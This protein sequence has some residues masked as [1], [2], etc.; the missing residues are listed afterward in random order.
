MEITSIAVRF[1]SLQA[2]LRELTEEDLGNRGVLLLPMFFDALTERELSELSRLFHQYI[3]SYVEESAAAQLLCCAIVF[4]ILSRLDRLA[5][6]RAA[7]ARKKYSNYYVRR[8][9]YLI[10]S[11]YAERLTLASVAAELGITPAYFSALYKESAGVCFSER[12]SEVRLKKAEELLTSSPLSV[13]AIAEQVGLG[14]E[15]NL[16]KRFKQYFGMNLREYR[17]VARE[18]TLYHE[19]PTRKKE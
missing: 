2:E 15:S 9:D 10:E 17:C 6:R 8:A 1:S 11:R 13:S 16:R 18:Q 14:D 7:H 19:K 4:E 5:R 12:L 3:Q